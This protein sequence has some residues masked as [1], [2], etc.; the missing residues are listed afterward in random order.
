MCLDVVLSALKILKLRYVKRHWALFFGTVN[1]DINLKCLLRMILLV[2]VDIEEV[3]GGGDHCG[4]AVEIG[5]AMVQRLW[6]LKTKFPHMLLMEKMSMP[7][8]L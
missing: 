7:I 1:I 3:E 4:S 2:I 5:L 8:N 6:N